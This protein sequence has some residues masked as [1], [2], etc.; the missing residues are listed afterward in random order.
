MGRITD[1]ERDDAGP[2]NDGPPRWATWLLSRFSPIGLADELQ[3]DLLEMYTYWLRTGGV[4]AARWRYGVAVLRLI[5]PFTRLTPNQTYPYSQPER[6]PPACRTTS[7]FHPAMIRNYFT[8][9]WRNLRNHPAYSLLTIVGLTLGL[10]SCLLMTLYI[11]DEWS[12]DRFHTNANRIY[13]VN[14]YTQFGGTVQDFAQAADPIGPTL[15]Q[16]YPQVE[17][18][19]RFYQENGSRLVKKGAELIEEARTVYADSTLFTVFTLPLSSGNPQTALTQP[20]SVVVSESMAR[21]YLGSPNA[22]G[23]TLIVDNLAYT[24]SGVMKDIP[25]NAQ[26]HF[27]FVFP[28]SGLTYRWGNFLTSN[29]QTYILLKEGVDYRDVNTYLAQIIKKYVY[30]LAKDEL[31]LSSPEDFNR[32][33]TRFTMT[34]QPLTDIHLHSDRQYE[35]EPN[36]NAQ[37][38][39]IFGVVALFV[40]VIACINFMNL[41]TARSS[42]RAKEVGIRK[43][44][45]TDRTALVGQFLT[46]S[47]LLVVLSMGL[48]LGLAAVAMPLFNDLSGKDLS[49]GHFLSPPILL[50][51]GGLPLVVGVLAGSYPA[52]YLSNFGPIS[53]LKGKTGGRQW[54]NSFR[55]A[56]VVFQFGASVVLIIGTI[57]VYRQLGYIRTKN[58]GFAKDQV[59]IIDGTQA[60]GPQAESFRDEVVNLSG[61]LRGTLSGFL[62][63]APAHRNGRTFARQADAT[64]DN[65]LATQSWTVDESYLETMGMRLLKG[66]NFSAS[67][68]AAANELIINEAM[69]KLLGYADP[70]GKP[71]YTGD[72]DQS[73][74]T[75]I[76]VVQNFHYESLRQ[77]I[78]PLALVS[79]HNEERA[80]FRLSPSSTSAVLS[81]VA[82]LWKARLP[83]AQLN[84]RFMD[85]A[86]DAMYRSEQRVGQIALLFAGLAIV[87]A[88]MGLFG[89]ATYTA[90]RRTREIGI[91]KVVGAST[92]EI[93]RLLSGHFLK[94]VLLAIVIAYPVGYYGMHRWLADFAYQV[95]LAWWIFAVSGLIAIGI[96]LLTVSYQTIK[97][98]LLNPVK[99]LR[100]E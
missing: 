20:R 50:L 30:P 88:C 2:R 68:G 97:A 91:R 42:G 40:L 83:D 95:D 55:S 25:H 33:D 10:T 86:F 79:G 9:A 80:A 19:V 14:T 87:I 39:A 8:I 52:F 74:F 12:Y 21:K 31:H 34:L 18:Y 78:G 61:V 13:R 81:Q 7:S 36:G 75:I 27:D 56:L 60:L 76:G 37:V 22:L 53:M 62:P 54:A 77:T 65:L 15:K 89:L 26:F 94:L 6:R 16:D 46:E 57:V 66:R 47:T 29:F 35:L 98:A 51:L 63:I 69:A 85:Q 67:A 1:R 3:G 44:L 17:A 24:V 71:L 41:A 82:A 43:V 45:G 100:S 93:V 92:F 11:A 90:E 70:V 73:P 58:L 99:S 49:I 84:Y 32:G 48:A 5:R 38:V 28:L 72:K 64:P 59:M 23:K 4:R 96:T